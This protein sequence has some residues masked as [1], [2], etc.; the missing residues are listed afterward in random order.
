MDTSGMD[1]AAGAGRGPGGGRRAGGPR[2]GWS[3]WSWL[4][5]GPCLG[6]SCLSGCGCGRRSPN[7]FATRQVDRSPAGPLKHRDLEVFKAA[8]GKFR[9]GRPGGE[10]RGIPLSSRASGPC[11][12]RRQRRRRGRLLHPGAGCHQVSGDGKRADITL[13]RARLTQARVDR[14]RAGCFSRAG[15]CCTASARCCPTTRPAARALT[16]SPGTDAGR[17]RLQRP[18]RPCR[19]EHQ[20]M[21][22][23]MLR[24]LATPSHG[25]VPR[26][27]DVARLVRCRRPRMAALALATASRRA[28]RSSRGR[29]KAARRPGTGPPRAPPGPRIMAPLLST[30]PSSCQLQRRSTRPAPAAGP[31]PA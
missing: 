30:A 13:P 31:S 9:W 18:S 11:P 17:G 14:S 25:D 19:A 27:A 26:S 29:Q 15:A 1:A 2:S 16:G 22:E 7:P 20:A 5:L 10:L 8:S 3:R 12:G 6:R 28:G 24:S 21:L 4:A 23:R